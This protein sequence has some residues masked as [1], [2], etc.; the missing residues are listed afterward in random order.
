[1][2]RASKHK[3]EK[4][5]TQNNRTPEENAGKTPIDALSFN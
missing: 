3:R 1:M 4:R 5:K 2:R